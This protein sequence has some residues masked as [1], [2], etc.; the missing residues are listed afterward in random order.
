MLSWYVMLVITEKSVNAA[1]LFV[2]NGVDNRA[3]ID[4]LVDTF[5]FITSNLK[6]ELAEVRAVHSGFNL[7]LLMSSLQSVLS[8]FSVDLLP[9]PFF[10]RYG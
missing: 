3:C 4:A 5:A 8:I 10:C 9:F 1:G 2:W 7:S 6:N